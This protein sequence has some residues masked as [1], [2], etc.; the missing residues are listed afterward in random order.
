MISTGDYIGYFVTVIVAFL[1]G[2]VFSR[3]IVKRYERK[4]NETRT[5]E[6][7]NR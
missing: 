7:Y 5:K 1:G 6:R 4:R 3:F 2:N